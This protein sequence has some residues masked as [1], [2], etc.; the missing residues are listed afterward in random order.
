V[1]SQLRPE[2]TINWRHLHSFISSADIFVENGDELGI[3]GSRNVENF[4]RLKDSDLV[5]STSIGLGIG[6]LTEHSLGS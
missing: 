2:F 4:R 6:E 1:A 5:T 3:L